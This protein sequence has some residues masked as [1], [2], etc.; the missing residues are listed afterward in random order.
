M[1]AQPLIIEPDSRPGAKPSGTS[2]GKAA[3]YRQQVPS[4]VTEMS[5]VYRPGWVHSVL[6]SLRY[7]P[8]V[9]IGTQSLAFRSDAIV[10][11]LA[12]LL[13]SFSLPDEHRFINS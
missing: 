2:G 10:K 11:S 8:F 1:A 7:A 4:F 5:L 3:A 6:Y 9:N 12:S 13:A